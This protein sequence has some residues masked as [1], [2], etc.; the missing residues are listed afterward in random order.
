MTK[1]NRGKDYEDAMVIER[2]QKDVMTISMVVDGLVESSAKLRQEADDLFVDVQ[3]LRTEF[4]EDLP[5]K[6][7]TLVKRMV[8]N[9][10]TNQV[11]EEVQ[12]EMKEIFGSQGDIEEDVEGNPLTPGEVENCNH[13]IYR[14]PVKCGKAQGSKFA[15]QCVC[16]TY[17][18]NEEGE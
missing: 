8:L 12:N 2:L 9:T 4:N 6:V 17:D 1:R 14:D 13:G 18:K 15:C 11:Q 10:I 7:G 5:K 16:H 3:A